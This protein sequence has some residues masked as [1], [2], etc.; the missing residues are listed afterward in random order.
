MR[1]SCGFSHLIGLRKTCRSRTCS[2]W[3]AMPTLGRP[4]CAPLDVVIATEEHMIESFMSSIGQK[5]L[6]TL[7]GHRRSGWITVREGGRPCESVVTCSRR[8]CGEVLNRQSGPHEW[9]EWKYA[10]PTVCHRRRTCKHCDASDIGSEVH[11]WDI[12][13][14][15]PE[16][17]CKWL[18]RSRRCLRVETCR[19]EHS[20]VTT[21][22]HTES[23]VSR[24]WGC[25]VYK[26]EESCKN[27]GAVQSGETREDVD[28]SQAYSK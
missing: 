1:G 11:E 2:T 26:W 3:R 16:C 22:S 15:S 14:R 8:G 20:W 12:E 21:S 24:G 23:S 25:I 5:V 18:R 6:C 17:Q 4:A 27:C 10:S 7:L 9:G 19:E 28:E 13:C